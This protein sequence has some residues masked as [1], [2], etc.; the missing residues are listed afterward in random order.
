MQNESKVP[1]IS[2]IDDY[3]AQQ[4]LDPAAF[5]DF[6][7]GRCL[8]IEEVLKAVIDALPPKKR[9]E[10]MLGL[11]AKMDIAIARLKDPVPDQGPKRQLT[12]A[13]FVHALMMMGINPTENDGSSGVPWPFHDEPTPSGD[14]A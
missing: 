9:A 2:N 6:I 3:T 14:D 10:A 4:E 5:S 1:H 12:D 13:G 8:A 7:L 11:Q